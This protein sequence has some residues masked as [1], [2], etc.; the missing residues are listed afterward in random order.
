MKRKFIIHVADI[1]SLLTHYTDG[2]VPLDAEVAKYG[3]H[4]TFGQQIALLMFSSQ[5]QDA[6]EA[7]AGP[8]RGISPGLKPLHIR[9]TGD[10]VIVLNADNQIVMEFEKPPPPRIQ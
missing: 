1:A 7:P 5:W 6:P 9:Y 2:I 4:R 3:P 10:R 8:D